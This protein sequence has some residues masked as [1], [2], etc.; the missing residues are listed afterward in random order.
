M[1]LKGKSATFYLSEEGRSFLDSVAGDGLYVFDVGN[2]RHG[3]I[4]ADVEDSEDLG[5]WI[6][7]KRRGGSKFFL[8]RWEFIIG[9]EIGEEKSKVIG[10]RG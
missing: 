2:G 1:N 3:I 8:L 5:V 9:I 10:L 6:R 4:T 7:V